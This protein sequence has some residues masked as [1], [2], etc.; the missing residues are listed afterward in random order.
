VPSWALVGRYEYLD[1]PFFTD[2]AGDPKD[3]Q[4]AVLV[5]VVYSFGGKI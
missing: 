4:H 2:D 5:G 1:D 3:S